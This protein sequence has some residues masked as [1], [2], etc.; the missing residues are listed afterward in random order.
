MK[1]GCEC[2]WC[3]EVRHYVRAVEFCL[4]R[5]LKREREGF[6]LPADHQDDYLTALGAIEA[7]LEKDNVLCP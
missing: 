1:G 6:P 4:R 5:A 3:R 2:D 7:I